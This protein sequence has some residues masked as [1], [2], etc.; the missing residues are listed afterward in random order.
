MF[1]VKTNHGL[2]PKQ[3]IQEAL[4]DASDGVN[5]VLEGVAPNNAP[6]VVVGYKYNK[7]KAILFVAIRRS[8]STRADKPYEMKFTEIDRS[9]CVRE[10]ERPHLCGLYFKRSNILDT[11]NQMRQS[12]LAFEKKWI[13]NDPYFR[14]KT[15]YDGVDCIDTWLLS[16]H[17]G[18]VYKNSERDE[19]GPFAMPV[20][21]FAGVLSHQ[22]LEYANRHYPT[23]GPNS[24]N[25]VDQDGTLSSITHKESASASN[26]NLVSETPNQLDTNGLLHTL[27]SAMNL[28]PARCKT[29]R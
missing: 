3:Y 7:K 16:E 5:I 27:L 10:V 21:N 26:A 28:H 2:F 17:H 19:D 24:I 4:K 13:T 29:D 8:V 1:Q 25:T 15:T 12:E 23:T 20:K 9:V 11:H 18:L 14:L 6:L 22:I